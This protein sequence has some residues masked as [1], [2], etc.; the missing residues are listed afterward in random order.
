MK[1]QL[2]PRHLLLL[3]L[4]GWINR[5]QQDAIDYL[6]TENRILREK[7][8]KKRIL[9]NDHQRRRLAIK[10]KI[11]GRK[12]LDEL[13][14]IVTPDTILRWHRELVARHWDYSKNRKSSGRPQV[15]EFIVELVLRMAR[16]NP[17]W[18]Y[19]R[20][21]GAPANLGHPVP[22][23]TVGNILKA[24]GFEPERVANGSQPGRPSATPT[25]TSWSPLTSPPLRL[26]PRPAW[27]L[28]TYSSSWNWRLDECASPEAPPIQTNR[29]WSRW[30][31]ISATLKRD[32]CAARSSS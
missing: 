4:V 12:M 22:D 32:S 25:G 30:P 16:E 26:G 21:Q 23:R 31:G 3:I 24:H 2:Q 18:G 11:L 17:M 6:L 28:A 7:R 14:T 9:L 10:G 15:A 19:D 8:G 1:S 29:G 20:I 13:A 27:S 5:R